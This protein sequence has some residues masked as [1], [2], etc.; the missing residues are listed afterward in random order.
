V[1]RDALRMIRL[2]ALVEDKRDAGMNS[3]KIN[4]WS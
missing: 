4:T 1:D 3:Q 2:L